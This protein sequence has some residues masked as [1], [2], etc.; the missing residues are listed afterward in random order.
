MDIGYGNGIAVG[1][2]KYALILVDQWTTQLFV[3]GMHGSSGAD[4]CE[5]LWKFFI[6][7][8]GFPHTL[9][10]DF[11]PRL[12]GGK[13]AV[14]LR[15]HGTHVRAAPPGRQDKNGFVENKWQSLTKMARSFLAEAKLPK[16]FWFWVLC[17]ANVCMNLL[18]ITQQQ[19]GIDDPSFWTT[20]Y[21]KF[22][23][24]KP[25]YCIFFLLVL[26]VL[27]VVSA[28]V[29]MIILLLNHSLF[30]VLLLVVVNL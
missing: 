21:F 14:L 30:L 1:G 7:A 5:A 3:Y 17:E 11:D 9:Q 19:D 26:L 16:K 23:S 2:S 25:D 24:V 6:D 27:F 28:M 12:I 15:S 4:V 13:A 22:F 8:G 29:I 18:P 20:P 10:C